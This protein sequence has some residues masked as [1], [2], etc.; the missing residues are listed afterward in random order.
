MILGMRVR[1]SNAGKIARVCSIR[2]DAGGMTLALERKGKK[3][4]I[5]RSAIVGYKPNPKP[6]RDDVILTL[7]EP[8]E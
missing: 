8:I 7:A 2:S 5:P 1:I 4:F 6:W 3:Y